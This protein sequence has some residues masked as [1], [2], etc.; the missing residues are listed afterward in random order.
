MTARS[1]PHVFPSAPVDL[2]AVAVGSC[3]VILA[4]TECGAGGL[5]F[6]IER[7]D[8][9]S[10]CEK[11]VEIGKVGPHVAAFRDG[12][13]DPRTTYN[14]RVHAWNA[15]GDSSPSNVVEVTTPKAETELPTD[16]E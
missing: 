9:H 4:W 7:A 15:S 12:S 11:F 1:S 8:C 2:V 16:K 13:V 10:P 6:R 14:Y 5:G 3:Q